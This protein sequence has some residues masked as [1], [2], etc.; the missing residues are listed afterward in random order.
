MSET[1]A[2]Q[3]RYEIRRGGTVLCNGSIPNLGYSREVLLDMCRAGL[4]LYRD[5]RRMKLSE[6]K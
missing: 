2:A 5:G 1:P 4:A 3:S 6:I